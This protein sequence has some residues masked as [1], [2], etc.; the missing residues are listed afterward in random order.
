M[1]RM[2]SASPRANPIP[3][4]HGAAERQAQAMRWRTTLTGRDGDVTG[5]EGERC[6]SAARAA[7]L[8]S[9]A[10]PTGKVTWPLLA[11]CGTARRIATELNNRQG[12]PETYSAAAYARLG[13]SSIGRATDVGR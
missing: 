8:R 11:S 2:I 3:A 6:R 12:N 5:P 9:A 1:V 7:A 4:K 10:S 13:V